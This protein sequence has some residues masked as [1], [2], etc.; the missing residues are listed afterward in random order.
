[1][2]S[3][4]FSDLPEELRQAVLRKSH[5][6]GAV[7]RVKRLLSA[8]AIGLSIDGGVDEPT[9]ALYRRILAAT[10]TD[11][12]VLKAVQTFT[13]D[14]VNS[15][16]WAYNAERCCLTVEADLFARY[17][18]RPV[19]YSVTVDYT[20]VHNELELGEYPVL[21]NVLVRGVAKLHDQVVF[22]S[23][24]AHV[25]GREPIYCAKPS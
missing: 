25:V 23:S 18:L 14:L 12:H 6:L 15:L 7:A 5:G 11:R 4:T 17:I 19:L 21:R 1:M 8:A 20:A 13:S 16:E 24:F 9:T 10:T 3:P 22:K 2:A